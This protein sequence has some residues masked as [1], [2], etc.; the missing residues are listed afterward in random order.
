MEFLSAQSIDEVLQAL[1]QHGAKATLLAGGTDVMVQLERGEIKADLLLHIERLHE[2]TGIVSKDGCIE[3]G[4]L[5]CHRDLGTSKLLVS[6]YA[7]ICSAAA[8]VGAW[9]TQS[10]GTIGGN[11]CNASPA[12]DLIPPLLIHGAEVTLSSK[13]RGERSLRLGDFLLGRRQTARE[14]DELLTHISLES[15]PEHS[16]DVYLK[17]GRRNAMEVA[18][19]GLAL[20]LSLSDDNRTI[21]NV[22]IASCATG[23]VARRAT[24]VENILKGQ[25]YS[26]DLISEAGEALADGVTPIDDVRGSAAYRLMVLPR[27]LGRAMQVC[28]EKIESNS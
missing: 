26:T 7:S 22:R 5:C 6:N 14:A 23:P 20:R 28:K 8:S 17:V 15:V 16:A 2:L 27:L 1:A 11:I 19:I 9:Q 13:L 12:A 21:T 25:N 18:I 3:I 24:G 10:V 4:A